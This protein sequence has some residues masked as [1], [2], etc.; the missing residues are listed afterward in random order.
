MQIQCPRCRMTYAT[1]SGV[2]PRCPRCGDAAGAV[3]LP[4][5]PGA[6]PPAAEPPAAD[7]LIGQGIGGYRI[8]ARLGQGGM[9][10]VYKAEQIA[11]KRV[12]ALKMPREG[13]GRDARARAR[14][15]R[16]AQ[17]LAH[18]NHP[19]IVQIFDVGVVQSRGYIAM[20]Y[21]DGE[22]LGQRI[23]RQGAL[24]V[25]AGAPIF[26]ACCAALARAHRETII[27]R[28]IKPD[29][30]FI[31]TDGQPKIGDFGLA[32]PL[33]N[34]PALSGTGTIF[35]TPL[36]MSPEQ[37]EGLEVDARSDLY[38]LGAAFYHAWTGR[39]PHEGAT[40]ITIA[41]KHV[42]ESLRPANEVNAAVPPGLAAILS[43]ML[44]KRPQ[45]RYPTAETVLEAFEAWEKGA[46]PLPLSPAPAPSLSSRF[47]KNPLAAA[48]VG[49]G[50]I[51]AIAVVWQMAR[52]RPEPAKPALPTKGTDSTDAGVQHKDP[53]QDPS[54]FEGALKDRQEKVEALRAAIRNL[55]KEPEAGSKAALALA[56]DSLAQGKPVN[57][58]LILRSCRKIYA[59]YIDGH[60]DV[61]DEYDRLTQESLS[62]M[63]AGVRRQ[64]EDPRGRH[65]K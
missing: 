42:K 36:Y 17:T 20:E 26:K 59:A 3:T 33:E 21:V 49:A 12:V 40:S 39:P 48:A 32:K 45:D 22:T 2:S 65:V 38:S 62:K 13:F 11:L 64:F 29:N 35:G 6:G 57:A 27:H 10:T 15:E 4:V 18:L 55:S 37:A 16:E 5:M 46:E 34:A 1:A 47:R 58:C 53:M 41:L 7:P 23:A 19:N 54:I 52:P 43:R 9:S 61:K 25:A 51:V 50:L 8:L 28:D 24:P 60:Q 31:T 56:R 30:I 44:A 14:F 63:P